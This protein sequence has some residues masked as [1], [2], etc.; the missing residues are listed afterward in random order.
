MGL[1]VLTEAVIA[2]PQGGETSITSR[3]P[4]GVIT[5]A[6]GR[7]TLTIPW[8]IV[9]ASPHGGGDNRARLGIRGLEGGCRL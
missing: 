4:V 2:R 1:G 5:A 9:V 8:V 6:K 3:G 7:E